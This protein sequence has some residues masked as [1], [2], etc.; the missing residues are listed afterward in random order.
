MFSTRVEGHVGIGDIV[1]RQHDAGDDLD[2]EQKVRMA[3]KVYQMFRFRGVGKVS[4]VSCAKRSERQAR[5]EPARETG[6]RNVGRRTGHE[7]APQ[8]TLMRVADRKE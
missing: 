3:P 6:F 8:P 4:I 2:A 5:I 1:H 7:G